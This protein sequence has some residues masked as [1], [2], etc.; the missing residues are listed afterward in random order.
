MDEVGDFRWRLRQTL[1]RLVAGWTRS[2]VWSEDAN[3]RAMFGGSRN[4]SCT[5]TND[6]KRRHAAATSFTTKVFPIRILLCANG[7]TNFPCWSV[8]SKN[9]QAVWKTDRKIRRGYGNNWCA[10]ALGA[11]Y[12]S[13][14]RRVGTRRSSPHEADLAISGP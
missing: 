14:R 4:V 10:W 6:R 12:V 13:S 7:R 3:T 11:T 1:T 2:R 5:E 9:P 8:L